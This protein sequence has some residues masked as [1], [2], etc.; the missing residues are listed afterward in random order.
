L[1]LKPYYCSE[2]R[3]EQSRGRAKTDRD[4]CLMPLGEEGQIH[5]SDAARQKMDIPS[6]SHKERNG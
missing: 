6:T 1:R 5:C 4:L 3:A 2:K